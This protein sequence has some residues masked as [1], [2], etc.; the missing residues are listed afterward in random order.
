M[1]FHTTNLNESCHIHLLTPSAAVEDCGSEKYIL[2]CK[3]MITLTYKQIKY[4]NTL[5]YN[6]N[7]KCKINKFN[8]TSEN[9]LL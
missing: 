6:Y 4:K 5:I 7:W 3:K 9:L 1:M 2:R 8:Y